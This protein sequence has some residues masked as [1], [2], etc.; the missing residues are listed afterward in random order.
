MFNTAITRAESLVVAVG[1]PFLLLKTEKQMVKDPI[2]RW[3]GKCWSNFLKFCI[4]KRTIHF[5][6]SLKL[7]EDDQ[8]VHLG[9]LTAMVARQLGR[10]VLVSDH[11]F[12]LPEMM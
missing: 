12:I 4:E 1:N 10:S 3:K 2:Y 7:S 8:D 11:S 9:K 5:S 6:D